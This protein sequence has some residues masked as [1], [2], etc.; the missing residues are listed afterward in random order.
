MNVIVIYELCEDGKV[1]VFNCGFDIEK[2]EW[3]EVEG[4]VMFQG[5]FNV[6][7]F[8]VI[9]FWFFVGGYYVFVLD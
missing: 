1:S 5:D 8:F 3:D 2:C 7:S 9:F 6:V 4:V